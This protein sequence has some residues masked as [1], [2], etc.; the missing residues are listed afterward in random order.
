MK[1]EDFLSLLVYLLM[2][3]VALVIGLQI[4]G[5]A[6]DDLDLISN[7][8]RYGFA[9]AT[10]AIGL[11]VNVIL[12]EVGH[13]LGAL[14]GV[15]SVVSVNILG[16]AY[17]KTKSGW[18]FRVRRFEGLTGQTTIIAKKEKTKPYLYLFGPTI[19]V[20]LEFVA[21]VLVFLLTQKTSVFHHASLIVAGV[22]AMLL[23][24]NIMPFKLDNFTDGYYIVALSKK[25]NV[26]AYNELIRIESLIYNN[27]DITEVKSFDEITT[28]TARVSSY[29]LYELIDAKKWDEALA[30]IA[31]L[32]ANANKIEE[33]FIGRIK[34]Q[35][36]Y[37]Y[38]L[39]KAQEAVS[40]YW[41]NEL[42]AADRKFI[43]NDLT[44]E[45]MRGYLLYSGRVTKSR[46][47]CGFVVNRAQKA[48][49]NRINDYRKEAEIKLFSDAFAEIAKEPGNED[50]VLPE[51]K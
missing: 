27:E 15:Y 38:L 6:L 51:L 14:L 37:I 31:K 9:I 8:Q 12:F 7:F 34:A 18:K 35:K 26:E 4:I 30:L 2:L 32:E 11:L 42:N 43:S 17:Y 3:V 10:I 5:P 48:L 45:T 13:V 40:N 41:F 19:M 46:S 22:G 23:I 36:L 25:I 21:A 49:K 29:S 50:L 44:L 47:E 28:M 39:T 33:E 20:V 1:K 16:L 24:Y